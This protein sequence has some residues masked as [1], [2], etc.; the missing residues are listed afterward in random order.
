MGLGIRN[1][2]STHSQ[3]ELPLYSNLQAHFVLYCGPLTIP[4]PPWQMGFCMWIVL[5]G[6]MRRNPKGRNFGAKSIGHATSRG[7]ANELKWTCWS[8]PLFQIEKV[9]DK[10]V[11]SP[12]AQGH[13]VFCVP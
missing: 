3:V 7:T 6:G 13:H 8:K 1:C 9:P 4:K 2:T 5:P 11:D 12:N 10:Y